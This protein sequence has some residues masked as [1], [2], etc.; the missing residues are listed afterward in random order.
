MRLSGAAAIVRE[1]VAET[2]SYTA[3][4]REHW[5]CLRTVVGAFP[6]GQ[7]ALMLMV[8]RLR[9]VAGTGRYLEMTRLTEPVLTEQ[10]AMEQTAAA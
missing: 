3:F 4:P 8:A 6:D 9:H 5:L 7:S 1:V 10:T 2:R